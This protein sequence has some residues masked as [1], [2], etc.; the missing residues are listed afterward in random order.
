MPA[1]AEPQLAFTEQTGAL[2][3]SALAVPNM[4][5][6]A[7]GS[8]PTMSV[9][10]HTD[11]VSLFARGF[12]LSGRPGDI[13][14]TLVYEVSD[15][16]IPN[17]F[18]SVGPGRLTPDG[19]IAY[20]ISEPVPPSDAP[21]SPGLGYVF[22]GGEARRP[23][24]FDDGDLWAVDY[25]FTR[26][27]TILIPNPAETVVGRVKIA[28][29]TS[30]IP[31]DRIFFNYSLFDNVPLF[32]GGV[33]VNRYSPGFEKTALDGSASF[34]MRF[35][36]ASTL[37]SSYVINGRLDPGSVEFGN[38]YMVGK[39]LVA[40]SDRAA[41]STGLVLTV[42]TASDLR[43][44]FSDGQPLVHIKNQSVHLMPFIGWLYHTGR[45]FAQ[46]FFD[47]DLDTN[48]NRLLVNPRGTGLMPSGRIQDATLLDI[49]LS[50]GFWALRRSAEELR[51]PACI[52]GLAP[53]LELHL[54]RSLQRTDF[55]AT[56]D[57]VIGQPRR[58]TQL[59]ALVVGGAVECGV[60]DVLT[61]GYTMP[62]GNGSDQ[63]FD[64]ELR[65]FWNRFF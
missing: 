3:R 56:E 18:Y 45:F 32:P 52:R 28:E 63:Q 55:V 10:S 14:S 50:C 19:V 51:H 23:I 25:S 17:D 9:L 58:A 20:D 40:R 27:F 33:T 6:P 61:V 2:A 60:N 44:F 13:N 35:P 53:M 48:G 42:P 34:E 36:F 43:I 4:I 65:A 26:T 5:G 38:L 46:G 12:L 49:N 37:D 1:E 59:L 54:T 29:N 62:I 39:Y 7:F 57:F 16:N 21:T 31:Q 8:G 64:G 30:P 24:P 15:D 41:L 11:S 47:V 22:D